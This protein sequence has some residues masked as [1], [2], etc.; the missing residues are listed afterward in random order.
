MVQKEVAERLSTDPG[1]RNSSYTSLKRA[2]YA[3]SRILFDVPPSVFFPEPNVTSAIVEFRSDRS[4]PGFTNEKE[5]SI[6]LSLAKIAF[7]NRR[8]ML[9]RT[10]K[11]FGG[12]LE[13]AEVDGTKRPE[14]LELPSWLAIGTAGLVGG[15][16]VSQLS[17]DSK[18]EL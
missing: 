17:N 9:R 16:D 8:Q 13:R 14:A 11:D 1:G 15:L 7:G 18:D 3:S 6:A 12:I 5:T 2:F 4:R 10:L